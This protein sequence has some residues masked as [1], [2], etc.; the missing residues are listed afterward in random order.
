MLLRFYSTSPFRAVMERGWT[1]ATVLQQNSA[2]SIC[3]IAVSQFHRSVDTAAADGGAAAATDATAAR[4]GA[5]VTQ[6]E[7]GVEFPCS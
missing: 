7:N 6:L 5:T 4:T 2:S 3:D 1:V